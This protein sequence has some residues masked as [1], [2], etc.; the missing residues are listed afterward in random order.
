MEVYPQVTEC[1]QT[2]V[3]SMLQNRFC[4]ME[5][6]I[7]LLQ[8]QIQCSTQMPHV[9]S[10][11]L[12]CHRHSW[13]LSDAYVFHRSCI[14]SLCLKEMTSES[15]YMFLHV[16]WVS[17]LHLHPMEINL[18]GEDHQ[19]VRMGFNCQTE[20]CTVILG[21]VRYPPGLQLLYQKS[22]ERFHRQFNT[23]QPHAAVLFQM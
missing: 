8:L 13:L 6:H 21:T 18:V 14:I 22:G 16:R 9:V 15:K 23:C 2:H 17:K 20:T 7:S 4:P 12:R 5:K 10:C 1:K 3:T 19:P 11:N